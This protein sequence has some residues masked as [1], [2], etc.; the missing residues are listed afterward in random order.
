MKNEI[1]CSRLISTTRQAPAKLLLIHTMWATIQCTMTSAGCQTMGP[2]TDHPLPLHKV[3]MVD[4]H[5]QVDP[6][7]QPQDDLRPRQAHLRHPQGPWEVTSHSIPSS[8]CTMWPRQLS[9][10]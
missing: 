9:L 6:P 1:W 2:W 3:L 7:R 10:Q 8:M 5:L 4:L